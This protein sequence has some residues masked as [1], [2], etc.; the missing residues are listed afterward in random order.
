MNIPLIITIV[1]A[2]TL[3]VVFVWYV[4]AQINKDFPNKEEEKAN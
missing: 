2:I 4:K 1:I 3:F